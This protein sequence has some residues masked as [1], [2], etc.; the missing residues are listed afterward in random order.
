MWGSQLGNAVKKIE[1]L[2]LRLLQKD[3]EV[4]S[5]YQNSRDLPLTKHTRFQPC[6]KL[7]SSQLSSQHLHRQSS[8]QRRRLPR[9]GSGHFLQ[10]TTGNDRL[11]RQLPRVVAGL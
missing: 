2:E 7:L 8:S 3:T 10:M 11:L 6:A 5:T 4:S 9:P 1:E